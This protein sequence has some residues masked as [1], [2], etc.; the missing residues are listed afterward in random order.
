MKIPLYKVLNAQ[1]QIKNLLAVDFD[2]N[3]SWRIS[4]MVRKIQPELE[5]YTAK[6]KAII[7]ELCDKDEE[8]KPKRTSAGLGKTQKY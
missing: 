5:Q 8:D 7:E 6:R 1:E 3:I 4:T 2:T